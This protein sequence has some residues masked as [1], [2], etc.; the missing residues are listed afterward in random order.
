MILGWAVSF[1]N[2]L[3]GGLVIS[4]A[5]RNEG[6]GF[7]N[8]V[9]LSLVVRIFAVIGVLFILIYFFNI[10]KI[11]LAVSMFFFYIVF[12]ILEIRF[13]SGNTVKK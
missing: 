10:D 5:F 12:L 2:V 6:K 11:A 13:L 8:K 1:L 3:F 4:N 9:L 7:I